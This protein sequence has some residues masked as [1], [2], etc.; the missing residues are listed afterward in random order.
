MCIWKRKKNV[1]GSAGSG[2]SGVDGAQKTDRWA[3][4]NRSLDRDTAIGRR[5]RLL[6]AA[7]LVALGVVIVFHKSLRPLSVASVA[8]G[9]EATAQ[10]VASPT[11]AG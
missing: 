8:V 4:I 2:V 1:A 7:I 5:K 6:L 10:T 3:E 9:V 11:H